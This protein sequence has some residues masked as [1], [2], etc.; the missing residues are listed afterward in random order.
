VYHV[1]EWAKKN[2]PEPGECEEPLTLALL[3]DP[4]FGSLLRGSSSLMP[5]HYRQFAR[6]MAQYLL[7]LYWFDI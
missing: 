5:K 2:P 4:G 6:G 3:T 1:V 7:D